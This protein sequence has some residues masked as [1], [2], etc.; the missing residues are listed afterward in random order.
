MKI[1]YRNTLEINQQAEKIIDGVN[2][3]DYDSTVFKN[4]SSRCVMS[5][6]VPITREFVGQ[7]EES[8]Y[9]VKEIEK[10][11]KSDI[12]YSEIA[13]ISRVNSYLTDIKETL[14]R[15]K[16]STIPLEEVNP[17]SKNNVYIGTMHSIKGFEFKVV[18]LVGMNEDMVPYKYH[19][20]KLEHSRE[21]EDFKNKE[22]SLLYVAMTRARDHLYI[23][24]SKQ[25][26]KWIK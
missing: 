5:G 4:K 17:I 19:L 3:K 22:R 12:N 6:Q 21:I 10:I 18:F 7:E 11:I 14:N 9:V 20:N 2:F 24:S 26:S 25:K 16:I 13:I 1:N 23:L 15:L 8:K